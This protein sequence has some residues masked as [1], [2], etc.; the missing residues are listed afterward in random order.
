M[1][2]QFLPGVKDFSFLQSIQI[3]CA[4]TQPPIQW[5]MR[6]LSW[7]VKAAVV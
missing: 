4:V 3:G 5:I 7:G 2:I 6:V 1:T